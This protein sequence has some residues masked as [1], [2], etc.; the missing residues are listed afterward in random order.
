MDDICEDHSSAFAPRMHP[1][2]NRKGGEHLPDHKRGVGAPA[3]HTKGKMPS[4]LQPDHG[5]HRGAG[6]HK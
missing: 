4:Q 2:G 3:M 6:K 5:V 1:E